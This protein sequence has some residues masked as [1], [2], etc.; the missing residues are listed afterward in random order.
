DSFRLA[1]H[2]DHIEHLVPIK[3]LDP[4]EG[5]LPLQRLKCAEE[6]L[7]ACLTAR[8]E[9]SRHLDATKGAI[10]EK[11]AVFARKRNALGDRL[12]DDVHRQ[13]GESVDVRLARPVIAALHSV[14][15]EPI[16]AVA[17]VLIIFRCIDSA[18]RGDGMRPAR[19][20]VKDETLYVVSELAK[21]SRR[22][23]TGKTSADDN[24]VVL[25]L[26]GRIDELV[27]RLCVRPLA[28]DGSWRSFGIE[29]HSCVIRRAGIP[30][31]AAVRLARPLLGRRRGRPA[32]A[33]GTAALRYRRIFS[34]PSS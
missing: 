22:G 33:A 10:L 4:A 29:S 25:A 3:H 19:R 14:I 9:R 18:L 21:R 32:T 6:K 13:L 5:D 34:Q 23:R 8:I 30:P 24:N 16:N 17:I 28:P 2:N 11:S 27:M 20:I 15:E 7:L 12:I 26:I 31:A 1:V